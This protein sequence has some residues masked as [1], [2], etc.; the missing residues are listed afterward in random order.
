MSLA[1]RLELGH[2]SLKEV[3]GEVRELQTK[4]AQAEARRVELEGILD[5]FE[6]YPSWRSR[7][8][9]LQAILDKSE[10][11]VS[12]LEKRLSQAMQLAR[13]FNPAC[14][15]PIEEILE[16]RAAMKEAGNET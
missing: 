6:D 11:R 16:Q 7:Y 14:S 8:Y 13:E 3:A 2:V 9:D 15:K 5:G 1:D 10:A 12:E 4:L